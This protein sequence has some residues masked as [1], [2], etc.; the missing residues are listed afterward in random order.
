[1]KLYPQSGLMVI[2]GNRLSEKEQGQE[3][4]GKGETG[5]DKMQWTVRLEIKKGSRIRRGGWL[6]ERRRLIWGTEDKR[7][8]ILSREKGIDFSP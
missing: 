1:M 7:R 8:S 4:K 2:Q 5:Q 6:E 3:I